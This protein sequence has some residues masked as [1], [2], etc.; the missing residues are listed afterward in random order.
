MNKFANIYLTHLQK[1]A[2]Y[3]SKDITRD[4]MG[5]RKYPF[6]YLTGELK[7]VG[8]GI[9][10]LNPAEISEEM[11]DSAYAA[12]MLAAQATGLNHPIFFADGQIKKFY[13]RIEVWKKIF[14]E[15]GIPFSVD[16]LSGGSNYAK[17]DKIRNAIRLAGG[18]IEDSEIEDFGSREGIEFEYPVRSGI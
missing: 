1:E 16:Y 9:K 17:P 14:D 12:Q 7:E 3:W 8:Q 2:V 5:G 15:K 18:E 4:I 6:S 11:G 10:N 13:D